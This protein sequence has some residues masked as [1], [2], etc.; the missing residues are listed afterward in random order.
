MRATDPDDAPFVHQAI[1]ALEEF[2]GRDLS[3]IHNKSAFL[4][5]I[6]KHHEKGA[7]PYGNDGAVQLGNKAPI[8]EL[9]SGL[10]ADGKIRA[11]DID[12]RARTFLSEVTLVL[13]LSSD[14]C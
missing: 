1:A 2:A 9:V 12:D 13:A 6:V 7:G 4:M 8:D 11:S 10:I 3:S 5:G 14:V